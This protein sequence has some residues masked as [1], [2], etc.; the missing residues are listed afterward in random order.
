MLSHLLD[1][2]LHLNVYL[3][4]WVHL[5]GAWTYLLLFI[6]LF[7]ETGLVIFPLLPGDSLLFA[8]GSL[9]TL[10]DA[11]LNVAIVCA[12]MFSAALSGDVTNYWVGRKIG[13]FLMENTRL[14][15]REHLQRTEEFYERYGAKTVMIARFV[16]IVR[17]I[18]PFVAGAGSMRWRR[19]IGFSITG[20]T[21]WILGITLAG[22]FFGNIP[23]VQKHFHYVIFGIIFVSLIPVLIHVVPRSKKRNSLG[24]ST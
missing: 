8:V 3:G 1:I 10:P 7:C 6:V 24:P 13:R 4:Q 11:H 9:A 12:V 22:Y 20:A 14:I 23:G 5:L 19:F 2:V 16:P 21:L 18:A 15:R 17:T